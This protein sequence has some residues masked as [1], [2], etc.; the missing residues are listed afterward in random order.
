MQIY[1]WLLQGGCSA[2]AFY[3]PPPLDRRLQCICSIS[4]VRFSEASIC[5]C[6]PTTFTTSFRVA[7]LRKPGFRAWMSDFNLKPALWHRNRGFK[8]F[9]ERG[10]KSSWGNTKWRKKIIGLLNEQE[11]RADARKPRDAAAVLFGL[12]FADNIHYKLWKPGFR[13]LNIPAQNRI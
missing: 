7:K 12:K 8:Q 11:S 6:T 4:L 13:A 2:Q 1:G 5:P 10:P 3:A 9:N